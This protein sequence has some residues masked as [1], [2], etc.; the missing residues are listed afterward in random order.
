MSHR[1]SLSLVLLVGIALVLG[2]C[3]AATPTPAPATAVAQAAEA[4]QETKSQFALAGTEWQLESMFGPVDPIPVVPGTYPSLGFGVDRY[5]GYGGC[6]WLVGMYQAEN[7]TLSLQAPA[8]TRGGCVTQP[9]GANQQA[10][11]L[12][13]LW[14]VTNYAVKDG[15]LVLYTTGNQQLMTL[16]PLEAVP[17]EGTT[18]EL[19][20]TFSTDGA[21]WAPAL[22]GAPITAKFDGKLLTGNA[23]CNDYQ[24]TYRR[25][26]DRLELDA[27]SVTL[28]TCVAPDGVME[29]EQ[30]YLELLKTAGT[31]QQYPRSIELLTRDS[32]P[33]LAYHARSQ[34]AP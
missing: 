14:S 28:K 21:Y 30:A 4:V 26:E 15:K 10:T 9:L 17:F 3:A 22:P 19:V 24:A 12:S 7:D 32:T 8:T 5:S 20:F 23:G 34:A 25:D 2:G 29:Q 18:W 11:Y 16:V 13:A 1:I 6:D 33:L 27:L 31:I